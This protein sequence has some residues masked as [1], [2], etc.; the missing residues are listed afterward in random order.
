MIYFAIMA[1]GK[2]TRF[3][4]KS[5]RDNPKQLLKLVGDKT[6]L[7]LTLNL[8]A[9]LCQPEQIFI[10]TEASLEK[11]IRTQVPDLPPENVI[12]EPVGK[13]TLPC[14]GMAALKMLKM[15]GD[16]SAVFASLPADQLIQNVEKFRQIL[17]FAKDLASELKILGQNPLITFGIIPTRPETG[18]GYIHYG[19][20]LQRDGS[21]QA[22]KVRNFVEKP[23][24]D[25][26]QKFLKSGRYLWNSGIF[27]C[28]IST[29][30]EAIKL[31][32]PDI[33]QQLMQL[34]ASI[35]T[36]KESEVLKQVY[37]Q[38]R[39][40]SVEHGI[41][42]KASNAVVIPSEIGW[43][44]LADWSSME[45]FWPKDDNANAYMGKFVGIDT[46][47][48]VIHSET[49]PITTIGIHGMVIIET[50]NAVLVCPKDRASEVRAL[51]E[52]LTKLKM[53]G[54]L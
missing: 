28:K 33:Y 21:F 6:M 15:G 25:R 54:I 36:A 9:P 19:S 51:L 13:S 12:V 11:A 2:G 10:V 43:D 23:S 29:L 16:S 41:M 44:H 49:K 3:W 40:L 34:D 45:T 22:F 37:P 18:Y 30:M 52:K 47:D 24:H 1:G 48:C 39:S 7:C 5:T 42:E 8:I 35:N 50:K 20:L 46:K 14:A 38:I 26:A 4:P 53:E 31:Y 17:L 32:A 27:M